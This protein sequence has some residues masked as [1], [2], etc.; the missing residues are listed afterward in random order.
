MGIIRR[1]LINCGM[2]RT[3]NIGPWP[4]LVHVMAC[5][6]FNYKFPVPFNQNASV[7]TQEYT[8][9][10]VVCKIAVDLFTLQ[11]TR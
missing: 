6:M 1:A 8:L 7:P 11:W 9:E 10:K 3:Y 4:P 2:M 5:R